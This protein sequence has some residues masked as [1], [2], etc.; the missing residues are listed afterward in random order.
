MFLSS[1]FWFLVTFGNKYMRIQKYYVIFVYM[2]QDKMGK[3]EKNG[4]KIMQPKWPKYQ[5]TKI[6]DERNK[7]A[8]QMGFS[9]DI[10]L[11][12]ELN[13]KRYFQYR[14]IFIKMNKNGLTNINLVLKHGK[15][16]VIN[17][18][19]MRFSHRQPPKFFEIEQANFQII[20]IIH[21]Y[22][23]KWALG[24]TQRHFM[25]EFYKWL[26]FTTSNEII[27]SIFFIHRL[28]SAISAFLKNCQNGTFLPMHEIWIFWGPN[29]FI[30]SG[31]VEKI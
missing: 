5:K 7:N 26:F 11:L 17:L 20:L 18:L 16:S 9:R 10:N 19:I 8:E 15:K 14:P 6:W 1:H 2:L 29:D 25:N 28:K 4:K 21:F 24:R 3:M 30:W 23:L 13:L 22:A 27:W 12:R 31:K